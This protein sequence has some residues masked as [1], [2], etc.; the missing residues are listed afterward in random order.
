MHLS[1]KCGQMPTSITECCSKLRLQPAC[2]LLT[3]LQRVHA[4][5][6]QG[7]LAQVQ[8]VVSVLASNL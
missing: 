5:L 2:A 7:E 6:L 8:V 4:G 3:P 1:L